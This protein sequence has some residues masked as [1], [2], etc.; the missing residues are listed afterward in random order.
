MASQKSAANAMEIDRLATQLA[1]D[2]HSKAFLPLAEAYC[3]VG[4]W[5]E[6]VSVLE[7]GLKHYPAF[8][9]AM[10]VLGRAYDQLKRPTMARTVLEGAIKLSP[11]NLRAHRTLIKIY[12]AQGLTQEALKSCGVILSLHPRDEEAMSI[13]ASL[14]AQEGQQATDTASLPQDSTLANEPQ[15][16][17][18]LETDNFSSTQVTS[19]SQSQTASHVEPVTG[20]AATVAVLESWLRSIERQRRD[21][22]TSGLSRP[23]P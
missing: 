11:D 6:A 21:R 3:K 22:P 5:E 1:K 23:N 4:M 13:Q 18:V 17:P 10:V 16:S 19:V 14:Q 9:T 7:D 15:P 2:P 12:A 8:I 20:H